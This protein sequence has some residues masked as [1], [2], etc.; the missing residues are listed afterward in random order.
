MIRTKTFRWLING[1][2]KQYESTD[3]SSRKH[4]SYI[5]MMEFL[6]LIGRE[7]II[8]ICSTAESRS[9]SDTHIVYYEDTG[10]D[11]SIINFPTE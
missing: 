11:E 10:L 1:S 3:Y 8:Q 5:A 9:L 4:N 6:N 2:H 7:R